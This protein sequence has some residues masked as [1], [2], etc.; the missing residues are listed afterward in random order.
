[1]AFD[2]S[3]LTFHQI[4]SQ[5]QPALPY[6]AIMEPDPS[7]LGP[8]GITVNGQVERLDTGAVHSL[9]RQ[10]EFSPFCILAVSRDGTRFAVQEIQARMRGDRMLH[11]IDSNDNTVRLTSGNGHDLVEAPLLANVSPKQLRV[12]F[13]RIGLNNFQQL[14]L[15]TAKDACCPIAL[16]S[17]QNQIALRTT[18]AKPSDCS[19]VVSF[20]E[21]NVDI[22][23]KLSVATW[24]G[25]SRAVLDSSGLLHLANSD[26]SI[27]ECTIV[28]RDGVTSGWIANGSCWGET[29]FLGDNEGISARVAYESAIQRFIDRLP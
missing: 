28:L 24:P 18:R 17:S 26:P 4:H 29:F 8:L 10:S 15:I 13:S 27:P 6:I 16:E 5:Q 12:R 14:T 25:G 3:Q 9:P 20:E 21:M 19:H 23:R 2:G 11:L 1:L 22:G 7:D